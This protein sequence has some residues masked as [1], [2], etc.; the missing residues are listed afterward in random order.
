MVTKGRPKSPNHKVMQTI[1]ID[2]DMLAKFRATGKG[3]QA[4]INQVLRE[5]L[6]DT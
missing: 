2:V 3:Y 1:R 4:K 5:A 6:N